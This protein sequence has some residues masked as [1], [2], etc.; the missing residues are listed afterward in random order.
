[1]AKKKNSI[2]MNIKSPNEKSHNLLKVLK[3]TF[4]A[5]Y[6]RCLEVK[7]LKLNLKSTKFQKKILYIKKNKIALMNIGKKQSIKR[8]FNETKKFLIFLIKKKLKS[9]R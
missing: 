1:V 9:D 3:N 6:L 2:S 4:S 7:K 5:Y 8:F